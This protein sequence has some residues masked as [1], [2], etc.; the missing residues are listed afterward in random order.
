MHQFLLAWGSRKQQPATQSVS[1]A[2]FLLL[3]QA[4]LRCGLLKTRALALRGSRKAHSLRPRL[5]PSAANDPASAPTRATGQ[6]P[7]RAWPSLRPAALS[8]LAHSI[9]LDASGPYSTLPA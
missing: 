7:L 1:R 8:R 2:L 9:S 3:S 6:S 5:R 4:L